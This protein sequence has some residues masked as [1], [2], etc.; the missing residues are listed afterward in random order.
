MKVF[1]GK[2]GW[3]TPAHFN[4]QMGNAVKNY[5]EVAFKKGTEPETEL[6]GELIIR[7]PDGTERPCFLSGYKKGTGE[8]VP[9]L[10]ILAPTKFG[11]PR[12]E[13]PKAVQTSLTGTRDTVDGHIDNNLTIDTDALPFY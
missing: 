11:D 7:Q 9:K 2:Y 8:I 5:I 10:V 6:E 12:K 4:T 13:E 1:K 3:S